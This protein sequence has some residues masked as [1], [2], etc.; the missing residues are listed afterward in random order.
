MAAAIERDE[1]GD[2]A[3][4]P[5]AA[6]Q[7]KRSN[8]EKPLALE[9]PLADPLT[10]IV[11]KTRATTEGCK[12]VDSGPIWLTG[13]AF[14][15]TEDGFADDIVECD[16]PH[17]S[18]R[19]DALPGERTWTEF[20]PSDEP[21]AWLAFSAG[22]VVGCTLCGEARGDCECEAE[23]YSTASGWEAVA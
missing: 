19:C 6:C 10:Y 2:P 16:V 15:L 8:G 3:A 1:G 23:T 18:G 20:S 11:L 9:E 5:D 22:A 7:P 4:K 14:A 13:E 17:R 12:G 21:S